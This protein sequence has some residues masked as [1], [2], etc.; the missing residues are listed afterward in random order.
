MTTFMALD[1]QEI[2]LPFLQQSELNGNKWTTMPPL[3]PSVDGTLLNTWFNYKYSVPI[4]LGSDLSAL[5]VRLEFIFVTRGLLSDS[6]EIPLSLS[7]SR[8]GP[9]FLVPRRFPILSFPARFSL[10]LVPFPNPPSYLT[11]HK[12]LNGTLNLSISCLWT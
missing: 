3:L 2:G 7:L 9:F 6:S 10:L 5:W 1:Y 11:G 4:N 12:M 8:F